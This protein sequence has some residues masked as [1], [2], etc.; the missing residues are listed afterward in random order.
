MKIISINLPE[1]DLEVIETFISQGRFPSR[2]EAIRYAVREFIKTELQ[3]EKKEKTF[4][5]RE[6]SKPREPEK[7]SFLDGLKTV[8]VGQFFTPKYHYYQESAKPIMNR[9]ERSFPMKKDGI[10]LAWKIYADTIRQNILPKR[11]IEEIIS[12]A[13]YL[14]S[15]FSK[16]TILIP[17][18]AELMEISKSSLRGAILRISLKVLFPHDI[19]VPR[20]SEKE[21]AYKFCKELALPIDFGEK[22]L[23]LLKRIR[24]IDKDFKK[25][26]NLSIIAAAIYIVSQNLGEKRSQARIANLARIS[27]VTLRDRIKKIKSTPGYKDFSEKIFAKESQSLNSYTESFLT[28]LKKEGINRFEI[29]YPEK[30]KTLLSKLDDLTK[31]S[32][33]NSH[34][35]ALLKSFKEVLE[36][37]KEPRNDKKNNDNNKNNES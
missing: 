13:F 6:K 4:I 32:D 30:F 16:T 10:K 5:E 18:I 24:N 26:G 20:I 11:S 21:L 25:E 12:A 1:N 36:K 15:R 34:E 37:K 19:K 14:A 22:A 9:F 17:D 31:K 2:S 29:Q 27:T 7:S 35:K 3:V 8:E 23:S 28:K 33:L